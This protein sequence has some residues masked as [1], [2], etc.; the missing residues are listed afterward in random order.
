MSN[1]DSIDIQVSTSVSSANAELDKLIMKLGA[2]SESLSSIGGKS[3]NFGTKIKSQSNNVTNGL[4]KMSASMN[5]ATKSTTSLASAFGSLYANFFWVIRGIKGLWNSIDNAANYM[6]SYNYFNVAFN[7]IAK[8]WS[9]EFENAEAYAK[10]FTDGMNEVFSKLSGIE[11]D[12]ENMR[13]TSNEVKNLGLNIK[14]VTQY[15]A[16]L[17]S[18]TNSVG[19]SGESSL[20]ASTTFTKLAGDLSSLY[21]VD[22]SSASTNLQ[23]GLIGQ[24]R[25]LY[26]YGIDITNATLQ[27]YAYGLGLEKAVSEMTQAEKMQLR[28]IAILDQSKVAWGNLANEIDQPSNQIRI[29]KNNLSEAAQVLGQLFIPL[30]SKVMPIVNGITIAVKNL[31]SNIAGIMGIKLEFGSS[32][33][34]DELADS[35]EDVSD[36]ID[37][38]ATSAKNAKTQLLG[39]DEL[40]INNPN[41]DSGSS[42]SSVSGGIDL[43]EDILKAAE[44]YEKA[45]G[46]AYAKMESRAQA[47]A[48]SLAGIFK[49]VEKLFKDIKIGD[50]FAVG[51]DT[52]NI[53]SGIFNLFSNAIASVDWHQVGQN[54]GLFLLGIDW[55]DVFSSL[56]GL[57][58]GAIGGIW[59]AYK[60][61]F[62]AAPLETAIIS[63][64][65][66]LKWTGL[67]KALFDGMSKAILSGNLFSNIATL[68]SG[69]LITDGGFLSGLANVFALTIGGAGTFKESLIVIFGEIAVKITGIA[70]IVS[71]GLLAIF[72]FIDMLNEG[73]NWLNEI[74]M[75]LGI[76]IT[77]VGAIILGAEATAVA[78]IAAIIAGIATL[79]IVVK[80]NWDSIV[81]WTSN[82]F[83]KVSGFFGDLWAKVSEIWSVVSTWF[84][85]NVIQ[86][87][88]NFFV[89][90][91][92]RV[93]QVFEGLWIIVQAI[94]KIASTWFNENVITPIVGFFSPIVNKISSF[95]ETIWNNIKSVWKSVAKW[96]S[97]TI[98]D[99]LSNAFETVC[100]NIS[101]FFSGLWNGIKGGVISAMNAVIGAIESGI[102][103]IVSG[104]NSIIGGFNDIV[105]WAAEVAEQDW[106]GVDLVSKV[107]LSRIPAYEVGGFPE[108]G[109]FFANHNELVGRFTNGRTAVANNEQIITGI[110]SG[111]ERAVVNVL[112]PYLQQLVQNTREVADKD[113]ATYIG[114][115][116]IARANR[117]GQRSLGMQL[118]T[119]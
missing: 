93:G 77:A 75:V 51:Q 11:F 104:I 109:L 117:R 38:V 74:L 44:E 29:F 26:K 46:E 9:G 60:W 21:N 99:P 8:D 18:V 45:W 47:V 22:Y 71:G 48:N 79:V 107:Y 78:V 58:G 2:V 17:G 76:G 65:A 41:S 81:E 50:W 101:G 92:T 84:N 83:D 66:L 73:F 86:P 112:A 85:E 91:S 64:V 49:P 10:S 116:D 31:L 89:G 1:M 7:K 119:E 39:I 59:D 82:L 103:F 6:E 67:S 69:G 98:I 110:E 20:A 24:S 102:N 30:L 88:I 115:R 13:L 27:T 25:A 61:T 14:E 95:F 113:F 28:M 70:S 106:D 100:D 105:S 90:L 42:E 19:L 114:D 34:T 56:G 37:D 43:T 97:K 3:T 12:H 40:N 4:N 35:Y 33:T 16:Q 62:D 53:V 54:V 108:D 55:T 52:S 111:V 96:F 94:W 72:N 87:V 32:Q 68:L 57:I 36:S 23:S 5:K 80:D 63:A 15:A 118:I